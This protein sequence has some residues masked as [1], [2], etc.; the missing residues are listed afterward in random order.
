MKGRLPS[1]VLG[2]HLEA[3]G[4]L[5]RLYDPA[6]KQRLLTPSEVRAAC[7]EEQQAL[8]DIKA[9]IQRLHREREELQREREPLCHEKEKLSHEQGELR[10]LP[11]DS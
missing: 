10:R 8:K 5:L 6:T 4:D 11:G 2:L 9:D 1:K 3:D 7:L